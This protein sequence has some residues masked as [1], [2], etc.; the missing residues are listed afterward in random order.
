MQGMLALLEKDPI[1]Y[2]KSCFSLPCHTVGCAI[3]SFTVGNSLKPNS[4][5][6]IQDLLPK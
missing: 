2:F 4:F 5:L 6:Q 3:F 1:L